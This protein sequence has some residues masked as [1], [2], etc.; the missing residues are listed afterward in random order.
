MR[1]AK[2]I[3]HVVQG[4]EPSDTSTLNSGEV[5]GEHLSACAMQMIG[6]S[7]RGLDKKATAMRHRPN[8]GKLA[9]LLGPSTFNR[10]QA[11]LN[12]HHTNVLSFTSATHLISPIHQP[13][14]GTGKSIES[15]IQI[16]HHCSQHQ[17]L[18]SRSSAFN[19]AKLEEYL[20]P[21]SNLAN[22]L[23]SSTPTASSKVFELGQCLTH[24]MCRHVVAASP[25]AHQARA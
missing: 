12:L 3:L 18:P 15:I 22:W 19:V 24:Q 7:K 1:A 16:L 2:S 14:T 20:H 9:C 23:L 25:T 4:A 11:R 6:V 5:E 10:G 17:A 8:P 13:P 21:E